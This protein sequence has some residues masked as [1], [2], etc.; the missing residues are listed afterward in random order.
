MKDEEIRQELSVTSLDP[1]DELARTDQ[2]S[3]FDS[4]RS[5]IRASPDP[6]RT[7]HET[8]RLTIGLGVGFG[9]YG[10]QIA[11]RRVRSGEGQE[12]DPTTSRRLRR[13]TATSQNRNL[14]GLFLGRKGDEIL[15]GALSRGRLRPS[16][17]ERGHSS[18]PRERSSCPRCRPDRQ[19]LNA[20]SEEA[21][22]RIFTPVNSAADQ[23]LRMTF[24]P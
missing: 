19:A 17:D 14:T 5:P 16:G 11:R 13:L 18:F 3:P 23:I 1:L 22:D 8:R 21:L 24:C 15:L 4:H 7:G 6:I 2:R 12:R 10:F 20:A 9:P